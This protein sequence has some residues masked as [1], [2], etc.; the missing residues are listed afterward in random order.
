M[1]ST[2]ELL[3]LTHKGKDH[4]PSDQVKT[5]IEP[6][7]TCRRH[8]GLHARERQAQDTSECVVDAHGPGHALLTVDRG[9]HLGTVLECHRSFAERVHDS[10]QVHEQH[11][12]PDP[13]ASAEG[14]IVIE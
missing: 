9:E 13:R 14:R 11:H 6:K 4:E 12:R 3:R 5:G 1:G 2:Y 10:E 8:D 7:C